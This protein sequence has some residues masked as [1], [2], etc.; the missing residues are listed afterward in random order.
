MSTDTATQTPQTSELGSVRF[1]EGTEGAFYHT[2]SYRIGTSD[3]PVVV[4][5]PESQEAAGK[6][7]GL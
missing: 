1:F 4:P 6:I 7:F 3:G 2:R 5:V